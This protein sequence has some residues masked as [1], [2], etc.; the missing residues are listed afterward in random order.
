MQELTKDIHLP[1]YMAYP[2]FLLSM[3]ISETAKLVYVLLLDRPRLSMKNDWVDDQGNVYLFYPIR[4]LAEN[5]RKSEMTVKNA[6]SDLQKHGLIRRQRQGNRT[7][8]KIYVRVSVRQ[9][10]FCPS[11][12]QNSASLTDRKLSLSNNKRNNKPVRNYDFDEGESL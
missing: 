11:D 5:C 1:P 3:D 6:L 10:S 12:G 8:N 7:A 4:E 2:K 9:T